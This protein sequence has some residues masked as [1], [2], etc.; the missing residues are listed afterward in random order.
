V[1]HAQGYGKRTPLREYGVHG[2][3]T[4]GVWATDYTRLEEIGP[5]VA[6]RV[7]EPRDQITVMTANGIV[8]RTPVSGIRVAGR[9]TR[10]V[11]VVNLLDGDSVAAVAVMTHDDLNRGVDDGGETDADLA[12][13]GGDTLSAQDGPNG[14]DVT[15]SEEDLA[16]AGE[17]RSPGI[18]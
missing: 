5:I 15:P 17:A 10:G 3:Y 14:N 4:Q 12:L 7:V 6:A 8:L 1:I 2:R 16:A 18:E 13:N 9:M 11:R